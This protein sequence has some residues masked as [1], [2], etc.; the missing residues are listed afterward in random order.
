MRGVA[1]LCDKQTLWVLAKEGGNVWV[2]GKEP[3]TVSSGQW[4]STTPAK[5]CK[6]Y[7]PEQVVFVLVVT[8]AAE[9]GSIELAL[10]RTSLDQ[11]AKL[12]EIPKNAKILDQVAVTIQQ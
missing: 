11:G 4:S 9:T 6:N 7:C 1:R 12:P 5:A 10:N 2:Q 3:M 8:D